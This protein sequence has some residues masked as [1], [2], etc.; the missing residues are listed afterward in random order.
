M[1]RYA[2]DRG[3]AAFYRHCQR[4][5]AAPPHANAE[6]SFDAVNRMVAFTADNE[7]QVLAAYAAGLAAGGSAEGEPGERANYGKGYF[8]AYLRDPD[9]NKIHIAYRGDLL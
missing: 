8:G 9:G 2:E 1:P 3:I 6:A 5:T 4:I 7:N